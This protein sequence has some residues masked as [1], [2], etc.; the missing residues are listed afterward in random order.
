MF[1]RIGCTVRMFSVGRVS[2]AVCRRILLCGLLA[3]IVLQSG[4]AVKARFMKPDEHATRAQKD[5]KAMFAAEPAT[6]QPLG[7]EQ[8]LARALKFNL[9]HR[10]AKIEQ[11]L[12][13]ERVDL[14]NTSLWPNGN[15][16]GEVSRRSNDSG[17]RSQ[18]LLT[19]EESLE[20]STSQERSSRYANVEFVWN[21]LDFGVSYVTAKQRHEE[22]LIFAEKKRKAGH[23]L[24]RDI[25]E[26]YLSSFIA[27]RYMPSLDGLL[28]EVGV[29]LDKYQ[30]LI[31][32]GV[33]KR[34]ALFVQRELLKVQGQLWALKEK[35]VGSKIR[36]QGL[37]Q[38]RPGKELVLEQPL[39]EKVY[40]P[41]PM[42]AADL[43]AIA[44]KSRPELRIEAFNERV[45]ALEA[46]KELLRLFPGLELGVGGSYDDNKFLFNNSWSTAGLRISWNLLNVLR[47]GKLRRLRFAERDLAVIRR[48]AL[49]VAVLM[50]VRLGIQKYLLQQRK[51]AQS[52]KLAAVNAK[53]WKIE[54]AS[55]KT[56]TKLE[57]LRAKTEAML[58]IIKRESAYAKLMTSRADLLHS[59]GI[60]LVPAEAEALPLEQSAVA[61]SE[62][63]REMMDF[64]FYSKL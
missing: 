30:R 25:F 50:Q 40:G 35:L 22:A 54:R 58:A 43:E 46:R 3:G 13:M 21:V 41:L 63:W 14:A 8:L 20:P 44:L 33:Q 51:Y 45:S 60:D 12:A 56:R 34:K 31:D 27:Q 36:L 6:N 39:S 61:I 15:V 28:D 48:Q 18:S 42:S 23:A 16:S 62:H 53:V 47:G 32:R 24:A 29:A 64:Y 57:L 37:V 5:L 7:F 49:S 26:N 9:D 4:C 59:I 17:G 52:T 19:G 38:V 10:V 2:G 55:V 11:A 1:P